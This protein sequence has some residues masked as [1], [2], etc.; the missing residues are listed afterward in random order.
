M[1]HSHWILI[2]ILALAAALIRI[3][4][5]L[6]GSAIRRSR[7]APLLDDLPGAIIVSLVG[8]SLADL[9]AFGWL[10]ATCAFATAW[11]TRDVIA[12]MIVGVASF[13]GLSYFLA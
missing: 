7:F 4:G 3:A 8:A 9:P 10:A 11:V 13:A 6:A 12:T 2:A 1:S 5:L